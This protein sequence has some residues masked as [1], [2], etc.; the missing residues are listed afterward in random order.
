MINAK[1]LKDFS[2]NCKKCLLDIV[3][4]LY[5]EKFQT[6]DQ[7]TITKPQKHQKQR[8]RTYRH[9]NQP[10]LIPINFL[11]KVD[12]SMKKGHKIHWPIVNG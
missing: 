9:N 10:N 1:L 7:P 12:P 8:N 6:G 5:S 4:L 3:N 2:N 11:R